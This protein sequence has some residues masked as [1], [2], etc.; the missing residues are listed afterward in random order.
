MA[1]EDKIWFNGIY[2][3]FRM[4]KRINELLLLLKENNTNMEEQEDNFLELTSVLI[5][6]IPYKLEYDRNK[7]I[8]TGIKLI[9]SDG[10]LLLGEYLNDIE[11][12]YD[13]ILKNNFVELVQ[14]IKIR[15]KYIHEP[16]NIKCVCFTC[17]GNNAYACF[18]YK[19]TNYELNTEK[20]VEIIKKL[21]DVYKKIELY[22]LYKVNELEEKDKDHPYILNMINN[23]FKDYNSNLNK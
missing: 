10:I 1:D 7:N 18:K 2:P 21:N 4:L 8:I 14:I 16:H 15:N 5:R 20:L 12:D 11:R 6:L 17:G 22:F 13:K 23:Y 3:Y 19:E 9:K